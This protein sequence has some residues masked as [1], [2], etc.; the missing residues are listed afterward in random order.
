VGGSGSPQLPVQPPPR[1]RCP[2]CGREIS[3]IERRRR[4]D[5]VYY[6][7]VHYLGYSKVGG[8]VRKN[9]RKCYLGPEEYV[10]VTRL[11]QDLGIVFEGAIEERRVLHYVD[12]LVE[13]LG[14]LEL[15][16]PTRVELVS[17]LLHYVGVLVRSVARDGDYPSLLSI[18][19]RLQQL[20]GEVGGLLE[21]L[22]AQGD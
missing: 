8:R 19:R 9:V 5:R 10:Y 22:A 21:R 6:Y 11:H 1:P 7:A 2:R 16:V 14:R 17:K 4:G 13:A 12:G 3:W 15:D 20:Q 18:A